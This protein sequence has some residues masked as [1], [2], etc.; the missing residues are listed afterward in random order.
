MEIKEIISQQ[1]EICQKYKVAHFDTSLDQ[2]IGVSKNLTSGTMPINALRY[3]PENETAGWY[4]WA[5][6]YS[7]ADDFFDPMHVTHLIDI[8]PSLLKYLGLPP[9]YRFQIDNKGYEDVWFDKKLLDIT[10]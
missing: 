5:G 10:K 9:G 4:I 3:P 8:Y 6:E 2:K 1:K 7:E